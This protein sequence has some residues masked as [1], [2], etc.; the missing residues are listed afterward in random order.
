MNELRKFK[1]SADFLANSSHIVESAATVVCIKVHKIV[2]LWCKTALGE[3][4]L[5]LP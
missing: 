3:V 2:S 4:G 5:S 1:H